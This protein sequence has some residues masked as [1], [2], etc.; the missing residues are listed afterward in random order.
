L[1]YTRGAAS[2][3]AGVELPLEVT[4]LV[5]VLVGVYVLGAR[6]DPPERVRIAFFAV[7]LALIVGVFVTPL[8]PLALH[9]FLWAHLLQNVVLAE[10]APA[11]LVLSLTPAAAAR[12]ERH[13]T[14]RVLTAPLVAL[15][16][17]L[18]TYFVWHLPWLYDAALHR[19]HWLL[20]VE[21][22]SYLVTGCLAWWPVVHGRYPSGVKAAYLFAAFALASPLG[23]LLALL[24]TPVYTVYR[25]APRI[26]DLSALAD[27]QLAGAT[28]AAEQAVV[29]FAVFAFFLVRF[30]QEEE[31]AGVF[32]E[33]KA[34]RPR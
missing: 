14:V 5:P 31:L 22:L 24:P 10:W 19:P 2:R 12:L 25:D 15:P 32:D 4:A 21:H 8:Q 13:R 17:W 23:L 9:S 34:S 27:Q 7:A 3:V 33:L 30:L 29:F 20:H 26:W 1:S 11:L 18:G 6:R 16:I 28:M